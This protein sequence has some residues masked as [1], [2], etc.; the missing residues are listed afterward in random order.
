MAA[1]AFYCYNPNKQYSI[2]LNSCAK[3][4]TS[5]F[6]SPDRAVILEA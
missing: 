2:S 6:I 1:L 4:N 5:Y 3:K